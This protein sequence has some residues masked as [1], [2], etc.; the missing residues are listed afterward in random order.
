MNTITNCNNGYFGSAAAKT[1]KTLDVITIIGTAVLT[2]AVLTI[3]MGLTFWH[4]GQ[5]VARIILG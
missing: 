5:F 3:V 1:K 4:N 2:S